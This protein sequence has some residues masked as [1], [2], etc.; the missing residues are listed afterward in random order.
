VPDEYIYSDLARSIIHGEGATVRGSSSHFPALLEPILASPL[1]LGDNIGLSY[2]LTQGLNALAMSLAAVP[3]YLLARRLGIDRIYALAAAIFAIAIPDLLLSGYILAEPIAYPLVLTAVLLG[4]SALDRPTVFR[5]LLFVVV[6]GAASFTRI[7]F[8]ALYVAFIGTMLFQTGL[9]PAA[10]RRFWPTLAAVGVPVVTYLAVKGEGAL[11]YYSGVFQFGFHPLGILR[12]GAVD[13]MLL[14]YASTLVIVPGA[15]T[16]LAAGAIR[17]RSQQERSY[18]RFVL[19]LA[20]VLLFESVLYA[21]NGSDRFQERYLFSLI[22]L[23]AIA[24]P[25]CLDRG[26]PLRLSAIAISVALVVVSM[27]VPL[28]PYTVGASTQDSPFLGAVAYLTARMGMGNGSLAVALVALPL[29][30]VAV[31]TSLRP[32]I[33]APAAVAMA[34]LAAS[35]GSLAA[36]S[37]LVSKT[38]W[39]EST[40]FTGDRSGIDHALA[41]KKA[42]LLNV[43]SGSRALALELMFWNRSIRDIIDVP[44]ATEI[45]AFGSESGAIANDGRLMVAGRPYRRPLVVINTGA[46]IQLSGAEPI[47]RDANWAL[48]RPG[49]LFR[50]SSITDGLYYDGWLAADGWTT[51]WPR[52]NGSLRGLVRY[53]LSLPPSLRFTES[54]TFLTSHFRRTVRIL[55][56]K[57][58]VVDVP[59]RGQ[60]GLAK[61]H[62]R[63]VPPLRIVLQG[64]ALSTQASVQVRRAP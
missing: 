41:G 17:P 11:G 15:V 40:Y 22:P 52:A 14:A 12:W 56:G 33:G 48:W 6:A 16:A 18:S 63:L 34:I 29:L 32:R 8:V 28:S 59:I 49:R 44:G 45:D 36:T 30:L 7:Q 20:G 54:V 50:F 21:T 26:R 2:R 5:Q 43:P 51:V 53:R 42:A 39:A 23:L 10:L 61:I 24:F 19:L 47:V 31:L 58:T 4:M 3:A 37:H 38:T 60:G 13:I 62:F 9:R 57:N 25:L 55:P 1:W 46:Q 64:R 35:L 27:R